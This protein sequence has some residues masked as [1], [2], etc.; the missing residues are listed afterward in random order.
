MKCCSNI[1]SYCSGT[2]TDVGMRFPILIFAAA[3]ELKVDPT[4]HKN[5]NSLVRKEKRSIHVYKSF[6]EIIYGVSHNSVQI[7]L[8]ILHKI[9]DYRIWVRFAQEDLLKCRRVL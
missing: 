4:K 2:A 1:W 5:F 9:T 7:F 3:A 8:K 6:P